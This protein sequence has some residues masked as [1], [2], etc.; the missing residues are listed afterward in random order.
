MSH[1]NVC[2][3]FRSV[4][5][6]IFNKV[7]FRK[8]GMSHDNVCDYFRS[9]CQDIFNKVDR[10]SGRIIVAYAALKEYQGVW[11]PICSH[12][13][14]DTQFMRALGGR[15]S[16][17]E[18]NLERWNDLLKRSTLTS[19]IGE[20]KPLWKNFTRH[21]LQ[22]EIIPQLRRETNVIC[23]NGAFTSYQEIE[24]SAGD[25]HPTWIWPKYGTYFSGDSHPFVASRFIRAVMDPNP[26]AIDRMFDCPS[27][28]YVPT[29]PYSVVGAL[30][31]VGRGLISS[32]CEA[33]RFV[34]GFVTPGRQLIHVPP[35]KYFTRQ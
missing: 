7:G 13:R 8:R 18:D 28:S 27:P 6:D 15:N 24:D 14:D 22:T 26:D 9:V 21:L 34:R 2:D 30:Q 4:C 20:Q 35:P 32:W 33:S 12:Y 5:Q 19:S 23:I 17:S 11:M 16:L 1:D 31:S 29:S 10:D 25:Q 3:Y